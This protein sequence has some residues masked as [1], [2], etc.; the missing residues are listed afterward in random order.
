MGARL[1]WHTGSLMNLVKH[2]ASSVQILGAEKALFRA[3]KTKHDTPK[4]GLVYHSQLVGQAPTK[5]KGK[6][7]RMLATKA[8][9]YCR[10][11]ALGDDGKSGFGA[12]HSAKLENR[13]RMLQQVG[14]TLLG[15]CKQKG[16]F[17]FTRT[18]ARCGSTLR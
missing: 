4:Y 3:L 15:T 5:L 13:V 17:A 8:S 7:S 6:V 12:E 2:S 16:K 9:L 11:D 1:I 18:R 14:M 10:V